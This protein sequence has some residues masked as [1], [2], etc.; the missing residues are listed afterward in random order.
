MLS[1]ISDARQCFT[2]KSGVADSFVDYSILFRCFGQHHRHLQ[3]RN[4]KKLSLAIGGAR[5]PKVLIM[6]TLCGHH[7]TNI[8]PVVEI[9]VL[10]F[11]YDYCQI[12]SQ[13]NNCTKVC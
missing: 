1:M 12:F 11:Q 9:P 5:R 8:A 13:L 4:T 2:V 10:Q 7:G 6:H 3:A